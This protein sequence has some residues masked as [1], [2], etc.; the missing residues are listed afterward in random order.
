LIVR[1]VRDMFRQVPVQREQLVLDDVVRLVTEWTHKRL[2]SAR[3]RLDLHL[4]AK[5][6]IQFG[7]GEIEHI[8]INLLD[9]ALEALKQVP[10]G[11]GQITLRTWIE[12]GWVC[13][14]VS[15]NGPGVP[16]HLKGSLFDLS[17]SSKPDG[18]GLGLWLARYLVERH[19]GTLQSIV[20]PSGGACFE[21][22]V[23]LT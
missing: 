12:T 13:L 3:V 9:N 6:P 20:T 5:I 21:L 11:Q 10:G 23:P 7:A 19:G 15:D 4:N 1:R 18:M 16:E 8:L 17:Q 22:R 2:D 14:A